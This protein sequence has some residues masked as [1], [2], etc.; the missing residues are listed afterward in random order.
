MCQGD[1]KELLRKNMDKSIILEV[2][3]DD[4]FNELDFFVK[5][6]ADSIYKQ[7]K[8][9]L[10]LKMFRTEINYSKIPVDYLKIFS[11]NADDFLTYPKNKIIVR[12]VMTE[13]EMENLVQKGFCFMQGSILTKLINQ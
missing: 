2:G 10:R 9:I 1:F 7:V 11:E 13:H 12:D 5:A 8:I 3:E 6:K 4:F